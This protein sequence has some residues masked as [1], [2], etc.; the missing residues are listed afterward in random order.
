[1]E[2][3][4]GPVKKQHT[5]QDM[6]L[7]GPESTPIRPTEVV[8][9]APGVTD[10]RAR[11]DVEVSDGGLLLLCYTVCARSDVGKAGNRCRV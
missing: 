3:E 4:S 8:D 6:P 5:C 1:M 10:Y 9:A 2:C 11:I 7:R